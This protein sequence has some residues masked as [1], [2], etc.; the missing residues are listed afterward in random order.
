MHIVP[1]KIAVTTVDTVEMS[2]LECVDVER[3]TQSRDRPSGAFLGLT[4]HVDA[5]IIPE[6]TSYT[7]HIEA[8]PSRATK[9][10]SR[11]NSA[12]EA[13]TAAWA[14]CRCAMLFFLALLITWV[15][16]LLKCRLSN[17]LLT[18]PAPVKYKPCL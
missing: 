3:Q 13:N 8:V 7:C 11:N 4:N 16:V 17:I 5:D 15:R 2:A 12:V 14:Y 1:G 6:I 10:R 18:D 9:V